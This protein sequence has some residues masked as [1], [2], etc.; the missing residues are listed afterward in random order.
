MLLSFN[1]KLIMLIPFADKAVFC[2]N[3][4]I[5]YPPNIWNVIFSKYLY[6]N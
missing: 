2:S 6:I 3:R 1:R 4:D 5:M